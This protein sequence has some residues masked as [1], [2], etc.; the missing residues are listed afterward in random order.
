MTVQKQQINN[1]TLSAVLVSL[2]TAL[3]LVEIFH[4]PLGGSV[5]LFSMLPVVMISC[6]LGTKWGLG[7]AFVF[8]L[9]QL[10]I[11][12]FKDG[13]FGW[14]LTAVSLI[15]TILLD[16][17]IPYTA[18]GLAGLLAKK[19]TLYICLMTTAVITFRFICHLISGVII[20]STWS[21]WDNIWLYSIVYNGL[22]MLPEL[23]MT[24]VGAGVLFSLPQ[25]KKLIK[26]S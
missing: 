13:I 20:F 5:T 8:A 25:I 19:G 9:L 22:Y 17:L 15:G 14:G 6:M 3:S 11:G 7:S 16:Y 18:L 24:V 4:M 26:S 12:I 1:L 10:L 23:V 21:K 2:G